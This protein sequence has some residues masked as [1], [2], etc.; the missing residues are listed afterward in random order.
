MKIA[1]DFLT[2]LGSYNRTMSLKSKGKGISKLNAILSSI[3]KQLW[4]K[5]KDTLNHAKFQ[6]KK[7]TSHPPLKE[8]NWECCKIKE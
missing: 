4:G 6:E 3:I 8:A 5:D 1:S 2:I 7:C